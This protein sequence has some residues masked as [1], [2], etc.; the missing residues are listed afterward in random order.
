MEMVNASGEPLLPDAKRNAAEA[1]KEL[2]HYFH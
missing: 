1:L 2:A